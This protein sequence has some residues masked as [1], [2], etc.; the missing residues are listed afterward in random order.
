MK[1]INKK[2]NERIILS[3]CLLLIF[4]YCCF[5]LYKQNEV[6]RK[7]LGR[8]MTLNDIL[9]TKICRYEL[10]ELNGTYTFYRIA[11][12]RNPCPEPLEIEL[13]NSGNSGLDGVIGKIGSSAAELG[14]RVYF[15]THNLTLRW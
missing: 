3:F 15:D 1:K 2:L 7:I 9:N 12:I 14:N 11:G 10:V 13:K 5:D 8:D 6:Y 4:L